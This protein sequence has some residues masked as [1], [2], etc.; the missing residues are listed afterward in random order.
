M[1]ST[2]TSVCIVSNKV[3]S[4]SETFIKS[5]IERLPSRTFFL[6]GHG[7][8]RFKCD[9]KPLIR[10]YFWGYSLSKLSRD[11]L[12]K[13][14]FFDERALVRFLRKRRIDAVLAEYGHVGTSVYPVCSRLGIP[15]IVHF[16]GRDAYSDSVIQNVGQHYA[17]L[18]RHASTIVVVSHSMEKQLLN[19]GASKSKI[20]YNPYGV[21]L[22]LFQNS[23]PDA[24]PPI[25][26]S[27]GRFVDKKAPYLTLI[28]FKSVAERFPEARIKMIG[29][30]HLQEA[31]T[32]LA[33]AL[34]ISNQVDFMGSCNHQTVAKTLAGARAFVQ[35]SIK[36]TY[37]DSEGTPV[38]ILEA[39]AA[40]I[41]VVATRHAGIQDAIQ[42]CSTGFLVEE[43]DIKA[44]EQY[45]LRLAE[46]PN[47]A[48]SLGKAA[49]ERVETYF[50]MDISIKNLWY[51]IKKSIDFDSKR[52]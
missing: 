52:A 38:G 2:E 21:D 4:Y 51:I 18:F 3:P 46:S 29:D 16:H 14:S 32:H 45:M 48:A 33:S 13:E 35:H 9:G 42:H 30:G 37:G 39:G 6:H 43:R 24:N 22:N 10:P 11:L 31:C 27:T 20:S 15:L 36:T 12:Q 28:A 19:L 8:P 50:S 49:R 41:P 34:G 5:H 1:Q 40:G 23:Y 7:F 47:L 44:M 26:V 17:N 25:F